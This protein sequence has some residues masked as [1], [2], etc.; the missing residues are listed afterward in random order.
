LLG[1][2]E[3]QSVT[4]FDQLTGGD[5]F[6]FRWLYLLA[7]GSGGL[8]VWHQRVTDDPLIDRS[9]FKGRSLQVALAV[10]F[11]VGASLV[12]SMVDVP[13]FINAVEVDI[14]DSA[15]AAGWVLSALT[16]AMAVAS[17]AGGR[18]T[19]RSGYRLP[20]V[21]GMGAAVVAYV[22]MGMTW[23]ADTSYWVLGAQLGVLGAGLGLVTAPTSS[24]VIDATEARKRGAAAATLMVVRLMGFSVGLSLLTA[25]G[26]AR[27]NA[28]RGDIDLPAITDP[29]FEEA[30]VEA[31]GTLT[32]QAIAETF[33]AAAVVTGI[34]LVLAFL[35]KNRSEPVV[36][37]S[38][39]PVTLGAS[40]PGVARVEIPEG[41]ERTAPE[42]TQ[43]LQP[44]TAFSADETE[45]FER[46]MGVPMSWLQRHSG[47]VVGGLGALV[48]LAFVLLAVLFGQLNDTKDEL[49]QTQEDL[50]RVEA[51]AALFASQVT[52]FQEQ[53]VAL[54]PTVGAGLDEAVAGLEE[55]ATSTIDF[56]VN[57]DEEVTIETQVVLDRE[58]QVPI[59]ETIPI[60]ESFETRIEVDT[61]L[62]F[63]VPLDVTVPIGIDVPID[64]EIDI[65][66][67]ETIPVSATVP[68]KLDIPISLK[69]SETQL[70]D[71]AASL[72]EGLKALKEVLA[73]LGG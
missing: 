6:N 52:G 68:V 44:V 3:I 33:L 35:I 54:E 4:G 60:K 29:G 39:D 16:A 19:A 25:W 53:I 51:G 28:L 15:V 41:W 12:I 30:V 18:M 23:E 8:F 70:A 63:S 56:V 38:A 11:I 13:I 22:L 24:A 20:M 67:N 21:L 62:G 48:A 59:N 69:V 46:E 49:V 66:V 43:E 42:I 45:Q 72:A 37:D 55:F 1:D 50:T 61:P 10:N 5:G 34:G 31:Q 2:A 26:L 57:I 9:V 32:A 47:A 73:G 14:E 17:Y 40:E 7:L 36:E 64:L 58:L 27:F 71:L 65:V